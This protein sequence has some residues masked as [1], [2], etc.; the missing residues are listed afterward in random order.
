MKKVIGGP[1]EN[2]K[3]IFSLSIKKVTKDKDMPWRLVCKMRAEKL[4]EIPCCSELA[5]EK[6]AEHFREA[7]FEKA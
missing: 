6:V 4:F 7:K 3:S 5:C 2:F 1:V